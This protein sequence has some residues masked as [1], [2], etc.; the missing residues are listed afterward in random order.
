M[1]DQRREQMNISLSRL[2]H[3]ELLTYIA[4]G[5]LT[6]R[7]DELIVELTRRLDS[8]VARI[9]YLQQELDDLMNPFD[10]AD[11]MSAEPEHA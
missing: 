3:D 11:E 6:D 9:E 8:A 5:A 1:D 10:E 7:P 2:T 4:I